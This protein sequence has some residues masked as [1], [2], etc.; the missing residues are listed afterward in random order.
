LRF[1]MLLPTLVVLAVPTRIMAGEP[2]CDALWQ[3]RNSIYK[4]GGFC[5]KTQKAIA[6]FGNSGCTY[7]DIRDVPLSDRDRQAV[8]QISRLEAR[9][10]CEAVLASGETFGPIELR[11]EL[12]PAASKKLVD[13]AESIHVSAEYYGNSK[14]SE[15]DNAPGDVRLG[16]EEFNML[17]GAP[18]TIPARTFDRKMLDR[19][20]DRTPVVNV[21]VYSSRNVFKYN[22]VDCASL[23]AP[24]VDLAKH[25]QPIFCKLIGEQG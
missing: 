24:V 16:D 10:R 23:Q 1:S 6:A 2:S 3:Q 11:I 22:I 19:I 13:N 8:D 21:N 17:P 12:S 4:S 15:A 20:Y 5:F 14:R 9:M 25:A 18:A 7:D